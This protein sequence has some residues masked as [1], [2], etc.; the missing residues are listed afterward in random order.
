MGQKFLIM[1]ENSS[2]LGDLKTPKST[3]TSCQ[4][5]IHFIFFTEHDYKV[6]TSFMKENKGYKLL[7]AAKWIFIRWLVP[8]RLFTVRST[9]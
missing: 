4:I 7:K 9:G 6:S 8:G 3:G 1:N 2:Y 5:E